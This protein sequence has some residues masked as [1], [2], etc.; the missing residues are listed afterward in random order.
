[1]STPLD[2]FAHPI[3]LSTPK[4]LVY[5]AWN[6]HIPFGML[7]IDLLRPNVFVELGTHSGASYCA[8]CQAILERGLTTQATAVD[9][10][11]GDEHSGTYGNEILIDLREYHN[12]LYGSFSTLVRCTFDEAA[13]AFQPS[14]IDL[15]HIDGLHTYEAVRHDYETWL[16]KM[17]SR[18]VMLFHDITVTHPGFGV[19]R[20]WGEV[21]TQYSSFEMLHSSGLGVLLVGIEAQNLLHALLDCTA[22]ERQ[23][24]N[25][26][27]VQLGHRL[28][29][30]VENERMRDLLQSQAEAIKNMDQDLAYWHQMARNPLIR[31]VRGSKRYGAVGMLRE[32]VQRLIDAK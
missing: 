19:Q 2:L 29:L 23:F 11:S 3:I 12:P 5:S 9:T 1:M 31:L 30:Q 4:R 24:L 14:S 28:E 16:P 8:F 20:F 27:F 13:M 10:W 18:G 15:L 17:S 25:R 26:L 7:L 21:K 6:G 22:D 32:G